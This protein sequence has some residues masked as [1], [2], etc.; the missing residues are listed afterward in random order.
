MVSKRIDWWSSSTFNATSLRLLSRNLLG[1]S[2]KIEFCNSC[3]SCDFCDFWDRARI[4]S[5]NNIASLNSCGSD[6]EVKIKF[7]S[8]ICQTAILMALCIVSISIFPQ[9]PFS[10]MWSTPAILAA[11]S[12][13]F[14]LYHKT[15]KSAGQTYDQEK[16][17]EKALK[18]RCQSMKRAP[19]IPL[20]KIS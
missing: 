6:D 1:P 3:D 5:S 7:A 14:E 4:Q 18:Y 9:G 16:R 13:N 11:C 20:N 17:L 12:P 2:C 8:Q 10:K 15:S 19:H